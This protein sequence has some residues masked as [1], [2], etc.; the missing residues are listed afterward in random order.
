MEEEEKTVTAAMDGAM[1]K[2]RQ[3]QPTGSPSSPVIMLVV[4]ATVVLVGLGLTYVVAGGSG[5]SSP[6]APAVSEGPDRAATTED[7]VALPDYVLASLP[8]VQEA[9]LFAVERPDVLVWVPCYCGCGGHSGHKSARNCF[10]T[11]GSTPSN[12]QFDTHGSNC[13]MCVSIAL[14]SKAMIEEGKSLTDIRTY[15]DEKYG[16]IGPGTDTPLPPA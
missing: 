1:D 2:R 5:S 11:E 4:A 6:A 10:V 14:D 15:I 12:M 9:Y 3:Q 16:Y 8:R 7:G 13:D